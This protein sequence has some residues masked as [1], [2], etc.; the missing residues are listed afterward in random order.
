MS[1]LSAMPWAILPI[2]LAVQGAIIIAS[3]HNP[4]STW[5]CHVPSRWEKKSLMT[6]CCDSVASVSGVMNSLPDGV[7]TTCTSAPRLTRLRM[8]RHDL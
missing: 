4:N 3:A 5:E 1:M 7:T 6:G 8:M 2:V